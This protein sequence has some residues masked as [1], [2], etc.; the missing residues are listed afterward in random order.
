MLW[1]KQ[2]IRKQLHATAAATVDTPE[3][4]TAATTWIVITPNFYTKVSKKLKYLNSLHKPQAKKR[5][6]I[7]KIYN[8]LHL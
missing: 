4:A 7:A 1:I 6:N 2:I 8:F 3:T 5:K